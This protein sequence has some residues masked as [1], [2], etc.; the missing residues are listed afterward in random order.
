LRPSPD[1]AKLCTVGALLLQNLL[2][3]AVGLASLSA[4]VA[5]LHLQERLVSRHV[6][7]HLGWNAVLVTGWLG[8]PLHELSHLAVAKLFGH[9]VVA[10]TL[11]DPDPVSGTLGYVRHAYSR[12][13]LWQL[14]GT[15]FIGVAPLAVGTGT[16]LLVLAWVLP[17]EAQHRLARQ[18][19]AL[20]HVSPELAWRGVGALA[21]AL[22]SAVWSARSVWLPLQ[23]YLAIAVAH[24]MAPSP[25]DL[26]GALPGLALLVGLLSVV[27]L[28]ASAARL[29]LGPVPCLLAPLLLLLPLT[30]ILLGLWAALAGTL[31]RLQRPLGRSRA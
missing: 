5:L 18:A 14:A 20:S 30:T 31:G 4:L 9:R 3:L 27:A 11:F 24:H 2:H 25:A 13:S 23:L 8:V 7:H 12:R 1:R 6:A 10:W 22:A 21:A 16:L 17:A 28:G 19:A 26:K 15:F 29:S